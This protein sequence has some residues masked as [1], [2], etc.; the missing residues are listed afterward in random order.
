VFIFA[1]VGVLVFDI[2]TAVSKMQSSTVFMEGIAVRPSVDQQTTGDTARPVSVSFGTSF[3]EI[4]LIEVLPIENC[5]DCTHHNL[6]NL[7]PIRTVGFGVY[8]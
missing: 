3:M 7:S 4:G 6:L 5:N 1:S 8:I 2:A